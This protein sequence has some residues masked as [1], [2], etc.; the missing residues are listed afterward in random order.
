MKNVKQAFGE[1]EAQE[2][3]QKFVRTAVLK[4]LYDIRVSYKL[5]LQFLTR[6]PTRQDGFQTL[7]RA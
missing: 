3:P 4:K 5:I 1:T 7:D 6:L 2:W